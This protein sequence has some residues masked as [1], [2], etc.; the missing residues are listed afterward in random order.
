MKALVQTKRRCERA[1]AAGSHQDEDDKR[2]RMSRIRE[3]IASGKNPEKE[4]GFSALV[5]LVTHVRYCAKKSAC[6]SFI[7]RLALPG[8]AASFAAKSF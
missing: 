2:E 4:E 1:F 6:Q 8:C 7:V 3:Q 5:E